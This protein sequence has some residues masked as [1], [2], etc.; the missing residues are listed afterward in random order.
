MFK[1]RNKLDGNIYAIKIIKL[2]YKKPEHCE[3][4]IREVTS[5]SK[6][7][8][9]NIVRYFQAWTEDVQSFSDSESSVESES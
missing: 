9:P 2:D 8:H 3:R 1:A 6:L 7:Y 5:F 4:I